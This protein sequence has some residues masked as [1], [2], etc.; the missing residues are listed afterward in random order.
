MLRKEGHKARLGLYTMATVTRVRG[1]G[2]LFLV[3]VG[4]GLVSGRKISISHGE[5]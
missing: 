4:D 5:S 3:K 2:I 1:T